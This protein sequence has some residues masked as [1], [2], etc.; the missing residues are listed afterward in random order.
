MG[1]NMDYMPKIFGANVI[2]GSFRGSK[3]HIANNGGVKGYYSCT[4]LQQ[5][6]LLLHK[7]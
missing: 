7:Q 5:F 2:F 6:L 3:K 4:V 1:P